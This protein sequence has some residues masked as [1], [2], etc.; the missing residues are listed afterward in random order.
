MTNQG[1]GKRCLPGRVAE[2]QREVCRG[3]TLAAARYLPRQAT[4]RGKLLGVASYPARQG[5]A[6]AILPYCAAMLLCCYSS[7]PA[8]VVLWVLPSVRGR[9]LCRRWCPVASGAG[10]G[11]IGFSHVQDRPDSLNGTAPAWHLMPLSPA[12][13]GR[14]D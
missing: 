1:P 7:V 11:G 8:S 3:K 10:A 13:R 4:K 2:P 14:C 12:V 9:T 6:A 5:F